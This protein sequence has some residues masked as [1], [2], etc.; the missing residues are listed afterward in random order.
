[1]TECTTLN[2]KGKNLVAN[3]NK[4]SKTIVIPLIFLICSGFIFFLILQPTIGEQ[5][6]KLNIL[7]ISDGTHDKFLESIHLDTSLEI[8]D[9]NDI[10]DIN[11]LDS[12]IDV[13]VLI[14]IILDTTHTLKLKE[15]IENGGGLFVICGPNLQENPKLLIDL[16][17]IDSSSDIRG[18]E[19]S[20][21]LFPEDTEHA[22]S[23]NVVWNSSPDVKNLTII[24]DLDYSVNN[25]IRVFPIS[26]NVEDE[27]YDYL[28]F[29]EKSIGDGQISILTA[30]M[31][32]SLNK[33]FMLWPYFNYF[34]YSILL[35]NQGDA[36]PK[37]Y[38]WS[39][40]PVPHIFEQSII[41][42]YVIIVA[43][44]AVFLY[45]TVKKSSNLHPIDIQDNLIL[46]KK[47]LQEVVEDTT[48]QIIDSKEITTKESTFESKEEPIIDKW[49]EI[50][51]HRQVSGFFVSLFLAIF[52]VIPQLVFN[53]FIIPRFIQPFPQASG[54][55]NYTVSLFQAIW[56]IFDMGTSFALAKYFAQYRVKNPEK[57]IHYI[58]IFIWWQILTGMLQIVIFAFIGSLIFPQTDLAH[59]SWIFIAHSL[60]QYPGFFMV[61]VYI[62]QGQ[63]R[64]DLHLISQ[65]LFSVVLGLVGQLI[66]IVVFREW[67]RANP[68]FGEVLGAS[69]GYAF[70]AYFAEWSGFF[71]TMWFFKKQGFSVKRLFRIDFTKEELKESLRYGYKL[72]LGNVLVPAVLLLQMLL[73]SAFLPNYASEFGYYN[74]ANTIVSV[75]SAVMMLAQTL[76]GGFSEAH[77]HNR[78]N[79][80][81][82]YI[83]EG[84]KWA[85]FITF[86]LFAALLAAGDYFIIGAAGP[87]WARSTFYLGILLLFQLLGPYSWLGDAIFQGTGK[88]L[89]A[90]LAWA[91][92]QTIR[93]VLLIIFIITIKQLIVV[94]IVYIIAL[95]VKDIFVWIII[96]IK[97]TNYK[98][99]PWSTFIAPGIA[100]FILYFLMRVLASL[101]WEIPLG[102]KIFNVLILYVAGTLGF[103]NIFAFLLG[104]LGGFDENTLKEL[105]KAAFMIGGL[106]YLNRVLYYA[107]NAGCKISPFHDR[108]KITIFDSA[109]EEAHSLTLEK[110]ALQI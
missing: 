107:A 79:L 20:Y 86:F 75:I 10:L 100:A 53:V 58:Q 60:I 19:E 72:M 102:D 84:L 51:M 106:G 41:L 36:I 78:D 47:P 64:S 76:L 44:I 104:F 70:G 93:A 94:V 85:N 46:V 9:S 40:S 4:S 26:D 22:I 108:F 95:A 30:W 99:Y 49:E 43:V 54:Y 67:G 50:G 61:F 25:I 15:Y 37:Y 77:S 33:E 62:F 27:N 65:I 16:S 109:M 3:R 2:M 1:M 21:I 38:E 90:G 17:I 71:I 69:I 34:L 39:Y 7:I 45:F 98:F 82:L 81:K 88:T 63:Q 42:V 80:V 5:Q 32:D 87:S 11:H 66:F 91:L 73:M 89:Y 52:L 12:T 23:K 14:D 18:N 103:I 57:A 48:K 31:D 101:I 105:K 74:L 92:E 6:P 35:S 13:V 110:K 28:L 68:I 29:G 96:R 8:D 24:E 83:Y 56:M 59:M 55:F 97:I